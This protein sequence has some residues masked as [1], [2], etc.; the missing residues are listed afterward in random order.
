MVILSNERLPLVNSAGMDSTGREVII[1]LTGRQLCNSRSFARNSRE[2]SSRNALRPSTT[3]KIF[4]NEEPLC[5]SNANTY[6]MAEHVVRSWRSL[7]TSPR[8]AGREGFLFD[9]LS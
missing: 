2:T 1:K 9:K 5:C 4:R 7:E 3:M 8:F 6:S